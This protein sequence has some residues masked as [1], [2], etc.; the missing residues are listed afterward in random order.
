MVTLDLP[1]MQRT[2]HFEVPVRTEPKSNA[3]E[4]GTEIVVK[5]LKPALH[6]Q[7]SRNSKKLR[8]T[9]GDVYSY[10][11][12][13]Q[14]FELT[15]DSIAVQPRRPC[16]WGED[17]VV[18]RSGDR[19]PAV[20]RIDETLGARLA[21][22]DCGTWQDDLGDSECRHCRGQ[23]LQRRE[24]RIW[25]WL[26][27]QRFTDK[28]DFGID[29]LR[30]GRKILLRD[31]SMFDWVDPDDPTANGEREYPIEVPSE[32]RIVGEIH[33]DHLWVPYQKNAFEFA[34][35]DWARVR[36][37]LR[38]EAPLRPNKARELNYQANTSPLA[39]L[40]AGY[41]RT[42]PGL[43]YLVPGDGRTALLS[44]A[45][46]WAELFQKG[47][48]AYQTDE[49]WYEQAALHDRPVADPEL[50]PAADPGGNAFSRAGLDDDALFEAPAPSP[51]PLVPAETEDD[52]RTRW[53]SSGAAVPDLQTSFGLRGRGSAL[54]VTGAWRVTSNRG[55][56]GPAER[57]AQPVY[58]ASGRGATVEIFIDDEHPIFTE[59]AVD[60]RDLVTVALADHLRTREGSSDDLGTL[61]AQLKEQCL[62]D[63]RVTGPFLKESADRL[64]DRIR[65]AMAP[66]VVGNSAGYWAM[67]LE[68]EQATTQQRFAAEGGRGSWDDTLSEGRWLDYAPAKSLTRLLVGRPDAFMD[69]RVFRASYTTLTDADARRGGLE[70]VTDLLSD[71][72]ALSDQPVRRRSEELQRGR[73]SISLL[74]DEL[75]ETA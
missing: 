44:R 29:F 36:R 20:I 32:G 65:E 21:C 41:R 74:S 62:N 49:V 5:E 4:H 57:P 3:G 47:E 18:V 35:P 67:L 73:L 37:T 8:D 19:I 40:F 10:L 28:K 51:V 15:V 55:R 72:A 2:G 45:R 6:D 22:L 58:I 39:L 12:A 71:V 68:P 70:R 54:Q 56:I 33:V 59:F 24:R 61:F 52:R 34:S 69:G 26:G 13:V 31:K 63:Q 27:I 46:E 30:N 7:L 38:G 14:N 75:I 66:V 64:L 48:A 9:L 53:K 1:E 23:R 43:K 17:R 42:D 50:E 25:G 11:L 60:V 16:I